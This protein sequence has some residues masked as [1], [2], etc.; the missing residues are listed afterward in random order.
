MKDDD[1]RTLAMYFS[2]LLEGGHSIQ[3][4]WQRH[5]MFI[6]PVVE[7]VL[8]AASEIPDDHCPVGEPFAKGGKWHRIINRVQANIQDLYEQEYQSRGGPFD[9]RT[10]AL[11]DWSFSG[12]MYAALFVTG[13]YVENPWWSKKNDR[14]A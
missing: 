14:E 5:S 6:R 10:L 1:L 9:S 2:A 3:H 8:I 11:G 12:F 7:R 13:E 4:G